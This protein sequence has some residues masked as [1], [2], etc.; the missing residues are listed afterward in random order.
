MRKQTYMSGRATKIF[1]PSLNGLR[2]IAAFV[3][4]IHHL[5]QIKLFFGLPSLFFKWHFIKIVGELGV[6]LFFTLSGFLITYLLLAEK[7]RFGTVFVKEFYIRRVLRIWPLYYLIVILGLFVFPHIPFFH[8]PQYTEGVHYKFG[9]KV[10]FYAILFPNIVSNL[11]AYMPFIAQ[12]WSIGIEEQFYLMWPWIVK[13]S[14]RYL[15]VL[16]TIVFGLILITNTLYFFA[17]H[18]ADISQASAKTKIVTLAYK[19]FS[20]LRIS[21]MAIGGIGAYFLFNLNMSV[22]R[23]LFL[24]LTQIL[25]LITVVLMM[26][27]GVEIPRVNHEFYSLFFIVLILNLA[28]N[29]KSLFNLEFKWLDYLGKISYSVY[30]WHGVAIMFGLHVARWLNPNIDDFLSNV[31]YYGLTFVVTF[32]LSAASYEWFE[33]QFLKFKHLFAKVQSGNLDKKSE[34][35]KQGMGQNTEGVFGQQ[36]I[37]KHSV[38]N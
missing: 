16:L 14:K 35:K 33:M 4:I 26:L 1:F 24:P 28:A 7:E 3:V 34:H 20:L 29:P 5:E 25:T 8:I 15:A 31:V 6:T 11:Y 23:P 13:W 18:S 27:L 38:T 12:T 22:L 17:D 19:F 32:M 37:G 30:M 10:F 9:T 21:C 36:N 2:F